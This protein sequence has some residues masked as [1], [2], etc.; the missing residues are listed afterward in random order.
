MHLLRKFSRKVAL[1][2]SGGVDSAVSGLLL[3]QKGFEV[4][5]VFMRNWD[6]L[7]EQ[8]YCKSNQDEEDA[9]WVCTKLDIPFKSVNYIKDYWNS[10]FSELIQQYING[11][12]PNPDILCNK[13]IKFGKFYDYAQ[14]VLDCDYIAT[15]HYANCSIDFMKQSSPENRAVHLLKAKDQRKDQTFFLCNISQNALSRTIF[16]LGNL[17]KRQ[18]KKIAVE[19]SLKRLADKKESVGICFVGTRSFKS[20]ISEYI[21]PSPGC[22]ID[23]ESGKVVGKH[24]G[25]HNFTIGQRCNLQGTEKPYYVVQKLKDSQD[26]HVAMGR[27]HRALFSNYFETELAHWI[28]DVPRQLVEPV[29]GVFECEFRFQHTHPLRK[30]TVMRTN[31]KLIV[32][33]LDEVSSLAPGQYAVFYLGD[34]CLGGAV[35]SDTGPSNY[36]LQSNKIE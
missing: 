24:N 19:S 5:G 16:P 6:Q 14:N 18:V 23:I 4:I 33:S 25:R 36:I 29:S 30:C 31:S 13:H 12:T 9:K 8:G 21:P 7:E 2:I 22:F 35:I 10:V 11:C 34:R 28:S 32:N 3:K 1:G 27:D 17:T 15:G 20:F 26:M